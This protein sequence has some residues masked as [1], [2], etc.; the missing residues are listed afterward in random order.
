[1]TI[2]TTER[3]DAATSAGS[4]LDRSMSVIVTAM[5]EEG[6]LRPAVGSV[7]RAVA[8]RFIRYEV[9]IVDDGSTDR[10]FEIAESLAAGNPRI[11]VHR[12]ERNLGLGRSYRIGID[13]AT[14][15]YTSWVAGNNML[16]QEA[17]E[18]VYDR[19]GE[20][21]MVISYILRDV[22]PF[23]RRVVSRAFTLGMNLLF[24]LNM[25]YYT[26]PCVFKSAVAKRFPIGAP[27]SV[28]V[29]E[30]LVRLLR[31]R[32]S[33][34]EVGLQPLPRSS[35]GT[36]TFRLKNVIDVFG[37]TLRLFWEL[38]VQHAFGLKGQPDIQVSGTDPEVRSR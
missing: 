13:L 8:S 16:S 31:A 9:I 30:L 22:R 14:Y 21:D 38:R 26:G 37:S 19:V 2:A 3:A 6:N 17:L 5:N 10:T 34:V 1:M 18:C 23:N 11:R 7:V 35:G 24:S 28:F 20:R 25:R 4:P 27:R 32:Q 12:N 15:E 36:K 33:Y 29:A